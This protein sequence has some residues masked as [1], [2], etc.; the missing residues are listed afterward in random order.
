[1]QVCQVETGQ[2][3]DREYSVLNSSCTI[4]L[5][6]AVP[7]L[8]KCTWWVE[9]EEM[10]PLPLSSNPCMTGFGKLGSSLMFCPFGNKI[11]S[12][13]SPNQRGKI[14]DQYVICLFCSP[15]HGNWLVTNP[16]LQLPPPQPLKFSM[17]QLS[18]RTVQYGASGQHRA[19]QVTLWSDYA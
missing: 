17:G 5:Q 16:E 13:Q 4:Y 6:S 7:V 2:T 3:V 18:W 11:I 15:K 14:S 10:L 1:M 9:P 8:V 19:Y 12:D